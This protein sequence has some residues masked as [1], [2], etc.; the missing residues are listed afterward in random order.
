LKVQLLKFEGSFV[1]ELSSVAGCQELPLLI[2]T[3]TAAIKPPPKS[4]D[5]PLIYCSSKIS[6]DT[7]E[8]GGL[9]S[10]VSVAFT[11]PLLRF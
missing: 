5:S 10:L 7:F 9:L 4:M 3:S 8:N 6:S 1:L 2:E 11:K